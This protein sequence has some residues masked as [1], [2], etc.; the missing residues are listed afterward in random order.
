MK[1]ISKFN[2][3]I[4]LFVLIIAVA[5]LQPITGLMV[6]AS[7]SSPPTIVGSNTNTCESGSFSCGVTVP[8]G[9]TTY[10]YGAT[11]GGSFN[12]TAIDFAEDLAVRN[13]GGQQSVII[14]HSASNTGT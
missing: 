11:I 2:K 10:F 5:L 1:G 6:S 13:N 9:G 12:I 8:P 3:T 14:G 4:P 7:A